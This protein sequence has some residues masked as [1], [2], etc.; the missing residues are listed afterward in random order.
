M[1]WRSNPYMPGM[2]FVIGLAAVTAW[3]VVS[4]I[5]GK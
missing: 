4:W 2:L 5:F 1:N 3:S